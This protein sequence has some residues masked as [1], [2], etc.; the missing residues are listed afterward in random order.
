MVQIKIFTRHY[1]QFLF[2]ELKYVGQLY[3]QMSQQLLGF[4]SR[5]AILRAL[6]KKVNFSSLQTLETRSMHLTAGLLLVL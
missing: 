4:A 5:Q 3:G 2:I 6:F 1:S